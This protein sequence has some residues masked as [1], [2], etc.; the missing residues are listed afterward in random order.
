MAEE[1]GIDHGPAGA[2]TSSSKSRGDD[3]CVTHVTL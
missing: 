3:I 2:D 1:A